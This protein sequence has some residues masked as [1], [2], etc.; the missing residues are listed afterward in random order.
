MSVYKVPRMLTGSASSG[1]PSSGANASI[2]CL[3]TSIR[4]TASKTYK[5]G[6]KIFY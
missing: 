4:V 6:K 1:L 3:L 2:N 5:M